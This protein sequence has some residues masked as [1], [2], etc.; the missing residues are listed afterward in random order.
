MAGIRHAFFTRRG[1]VSSGIYAGLNAG[2]GSEDRR[3]DVRENRRR[4]AAY[5]GST[6]SDVVTPWQIHSPD[7]VIVEAPFG[8]ERPKVDA[9]VTAT[10]GLPIG[11]VTADCGPVLF[12]DEKAGV[13]GAAHAGWK[14]ALGG[15][16]E[17]T[18]DAMERCG[19]RRENIVAVLGPTITAANYEI[20]ADR[21]A[22]FV[23]A[24][25]SYGRFFSAGVSDDKRQLDLPAFIVARLEAAG[26]QASFVGRCT[27][28]EE[29]RFFSFRRTTHRSEPDYG[30]QLAAIAIRA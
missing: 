29:D 15:V 9:I 12:A 10:P 30:R 26:V 11:V 1:G 22:V 18:I 13:V 16:L 27:Y 25:S 17:S 19:A 28:A 14:G 2:L 3:D 5:L 4:A 20:G 7:A 24:D 23:E 6:G 8:P 21:E